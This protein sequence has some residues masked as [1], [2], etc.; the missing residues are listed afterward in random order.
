MRLPRVPNSIAGPSRPRIPL[1]LPINAIHSSARYV[2]ARAA[3][4]THSPY[5][6]EAL[7]VPFPQ[8]PRA[9]SRTPARTE[10][11]L[12]DFEALGIKPGIA[13]ALR[14]SFSQVVHPTFCQAQLIPAVLEGKDVLLRDITGSGKSFGLLLAL[15]SRLRKG[16]APGKHPGRT[17]EIPL[18]TALLLVPH[19]NLA[20]QLQYW[21]RQLI[22]VSLFPDLAPVLSV[23]LRGTGTPMTEL[24]ERLRRTPPHILVGTA[25]ALVELAE[26]D[27]AALGIPRLRTIAVDEADDL[28]GVPGVF[29]SRKEQRNFAKHPP[30]ALSLLRA[31]LSER[32]KRPTSSVS[33]KSHDPLQAIFMSATLNRPVREFIKLELD[34]LSREKGGI[35]KVDV[36]N[37]RREFATRMRGKVEHYCLVVGEESVRDVRSASTDTRLNG[38]RQEDMDEEDLEEGD[39]DQPYPSANGTPN[40]DAAH[41]G[42]TSPSP[43]ADSPQQKTAQK[44]EPETPRQARAH[45][46]RG[47]IIHEL[48]LFSTPLDASE[49]PLLPL[50]LPSTQ[51]EIIP[52]YPSQMFETIAAAL[53]LDVRRLAVLFVP[54]QVS[55]RRVVDLFGGLGVRARG[56]DLGSGEGGRGALAGSTQLVSSPSTVP[57]RPSQEQQGPEAQA[58]E[59]QETQSPELLIT[60]FPHSRGLD[61]PALSHVFLLGAAP[62][63]TSYLHMAGRLGRRSALLAGVD[64]AAAGAVGMGPAG[65]GPAAAGWN[66]EEEVGPGKIITVVK[67]VM[68]PA[69]A[70]D[71][72]Y[73]GGP[74]Q[75]WGEERKVARLYRMMGVVPGRWAGEG[76]EDEGE[77][78]AEELEEEE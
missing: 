20:L 41:A 72:R 26:T 45:P 23:V 65:E 44:E 16:P 6:G 37:T 28:L 56:L 3:R 75:L 14:E 24:A 34:C 12:Q 30:P 42:S 21:A 19:S 57:Q 4:I 64:A 58:Q 73:G 52:N 62:S 33:R 1:S 10:V 11:Y 70:D 78:E 63:L 48:E 25:T 40:P 77:G 55:V 7:P 39:M 27:W 54:P 66:E 35:V 76:E 38:A 49:R 51:D 59:T 47:H 9:E 22:P 18:E 46:D 68:R 5:V 8:D 32:P 15:L 71:L 53:A 43:S 69:W 74:D 60:S 13:R 2:S 67:E 29:A 61:L 31:I 36:V 50:S 17:P